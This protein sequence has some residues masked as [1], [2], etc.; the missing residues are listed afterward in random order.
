MGFLG[1]SMVIEG[2]RKQHAPEQKCNDNAYEAML[3]FSTLVTVPWMRF[4][5]F[6][7]RIRLDNLEIRTIGDS[8]KISMKLGF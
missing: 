7:S 4:Q 6:K 3:T 8:K 5:F 2:A 1:L